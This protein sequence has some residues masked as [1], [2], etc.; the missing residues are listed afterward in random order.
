VA[1]FAVLV[2][3]LQRFRYAGQPLRG[4]DGKL[5]RVR[6]RIGLQL[7]LRQQ[8]GGVHASEAADEQ[9]PRGETEEQWWLSAIAASRR[10]APQAP[11][12][13]THAW[14]CQRKLVDVHRGR[15][16]DEERDVARR[17]Q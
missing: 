2:E 12:R 3:D 1:P 4:A 8:P 10:R 11:D 6:E 13:G 5:L 7:H 14:G 15:R 9:R 17:L 16:R